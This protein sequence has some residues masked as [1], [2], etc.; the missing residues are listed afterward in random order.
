MFMFELLR[1]FSFE[2]SVGLRIGRNILEGKISFTLYSPV[3][4]S[5]ILLR[6]S[7]PRSFKEG[8]EPKLLIFV[9]FNNFF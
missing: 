6:V 9:T 1:T 2:W 5:V 3:F 8:I 4:F 7:S